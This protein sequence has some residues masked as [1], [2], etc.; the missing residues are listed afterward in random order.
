MCLEQGTVGA[1]KTAPATHKAQT[2]LNAGRTVCV[3][4]ARLS[5]DHLLVAEQV[6][7]P[8]AGIL[9]R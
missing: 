7:P 5:F 6:L 1:D 3:D 8:F 2:I 9:L 4:E